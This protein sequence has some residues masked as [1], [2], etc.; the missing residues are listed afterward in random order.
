[1]AGPRWGLPT[2]SV[3][4][5]CMTCQLRFTANQARCTLARVRMKPDLRCHAMHAGP[6]PQVKPGAV[7][8]ALILV[9]CTAAA[10]CV[11]EEVPLVWS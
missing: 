2:M 8:L 11:Q 4:K 5:T 7:V 10:M 3:T 1:M 9:V 6:E